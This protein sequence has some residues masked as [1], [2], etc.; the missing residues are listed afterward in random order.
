MESGDDSVWGERGIGLP[1]KANAR[2]WRMVSQYEMILTTAALLAKE[3]G[4]GNSLTYQ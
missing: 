3:A 2:M 4:Y 1:E